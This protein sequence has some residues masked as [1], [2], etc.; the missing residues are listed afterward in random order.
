M[1]LCRMQQAEGVCCMVAQKMGV[2]VVGQAGKD[3]SHA[4]ACLSCAVT[5]P[6]SRSATVSLHY[7][8]K[9]MSRQCHFM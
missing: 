6:H 4:C 9:A 5:V 3:L 8:D 2:K 1:V 7:L